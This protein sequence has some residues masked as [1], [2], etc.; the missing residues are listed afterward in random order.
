MVSI[1]ELRHCSIH[2]IVDALLKILCFIVSSPFSFWPCR[3]LFLAEEE[4]DGGADNYDDGE[5]PEPAGS[6]SGFG[7]FEV[8]AD[9]G[10]VEE[11]DEFGLGVVAAVAGDVICAVGELELSEG[12]AG[13][14]FAFDVDCSVDGDAVF[15]DVDVEV[16]ES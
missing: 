11:A 14:V 4:D 13:V 2:S 6:K 1:T 8:E 3:S 15:G 10:V 5:R 7:S 9:V 12:V 16:E